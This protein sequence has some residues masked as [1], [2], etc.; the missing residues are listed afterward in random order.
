MSER[1]IQ[2]QKRYVPISDFCKQSGLSYATV[3][4][5]LKSGQLPHILTEGG[6][7]KIDTQSGIDAFTVLRRFDEL[8]KRLES[9][10]KLCKHLGVI[11]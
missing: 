1:V 9:I 8:E 11:L 5:M 7:E 4:H 10:D 3:K 6:H 2:K